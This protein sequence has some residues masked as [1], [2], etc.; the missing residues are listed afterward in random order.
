MAHNPPFA[1]EKPDLLRIHNEF[2]PAL[3]ENGVTDEQIDQMLLE[4]PRR[5]F[6]SGGAGAGAVGQLDHAA[7]PAGE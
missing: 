6:G 7:E 1:D 2:L 5:F 4:N 3:R